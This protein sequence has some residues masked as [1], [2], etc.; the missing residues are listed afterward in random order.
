MHHRH[1][2]ARCDRNHVRSE[3]AGPISLHDPPATVPGTLRASP[4][5]DPVCV[6]T[7]T[8]LLRKG[9]CS[10]FTT[11]TANPVLI[12][13]GRFDPA[14]RYQGAVTLARLLPRSRL[15][16]LDGWG[17]V[18]GSGSTLL[19]A[20]GTFGPDATVPVDLFF[21][22]SVE[23]AFEAARWLQEVH[24]GPPLEEAPGILG[25]L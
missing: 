12:V 15:L 16:T 2:F 11:P 21:D 23:L 19:S 18:S 6:L 10:L 7:R 5:S 24:G 13:G 3:R 9:P 1:L 4:G 22:A 17:H 25:T 20:G 8:S 14:T